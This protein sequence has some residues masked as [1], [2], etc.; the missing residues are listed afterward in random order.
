MAVAS[1][2]RR[3]AWRWLVPKVDAVRAIKLRRCRG[4]FSHV[5]ADNLIVSIY[6]A[7]K[8]QR[9]HI[10]H[11]R[12]IE[13]TDVKAAA[14]Q[15]SPVLYSREGTVEKVVEKIIAL[16][17]QGVQFATFPEAIV[18]YYPYFSTLQRPIELADQQLLLLDQAV[19]VPSEATHAIGDA[20]AQA[21]TVVS[22]GI[23][24]RDGSTI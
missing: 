23:N 5:N 22:I 12:Y 20:C 16:G 17:R 7:K 4:Q 24:E 18:P 1:T 6:H 11:E 2:T 14:V 8:A 15:I 19:T 21:G 9:R 3:S 13:M 10:Q